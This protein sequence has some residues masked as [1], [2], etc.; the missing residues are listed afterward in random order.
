[1]P[2]ATKS[3]KPIAMPA[4]RVVPVSKFKAQCLALVNGVHNGE[5]EII[6]TNH[7]QPIAKIVPIEAVERVPFIGSSKGFFKL[8]EGHDLVAPMAPDWQLG[9]DI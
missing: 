1:M 7:N 8:A 9:D 5:G 4:T 6:L 3:R 2:A